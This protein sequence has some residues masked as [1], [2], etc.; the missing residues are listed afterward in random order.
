[1]TKLKILI[2]DDEMDY[3]LIM[4][5]YF[6]EKGYGVNVAFTL[7][8]G[9][10]MLDSIIPDI[11]FL[12]NNLPDGKGWE[13]VEDIMAKRPDLKLYLISAYRQKTELSATI[14]NVTLWEKPISLSLL[15]NI[16]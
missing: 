13:C 3:C 7:R 16:F 5:S 14:P 11:L 8:E 6:E 4:Q 10:S 1:M 15:E 2:V 12:D 9:L